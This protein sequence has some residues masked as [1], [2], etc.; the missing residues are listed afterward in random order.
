MTGEQLFEYGVLGVTLFACIA[1]MVVKARRKIGA[2]GSTACGGSCGCGDAD[3]EA[4]MAAGAPCRPVVI[5]S[6]RDEGDRPLN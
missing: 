4:K 5:E 1:Y 6:P 2:F 3:M